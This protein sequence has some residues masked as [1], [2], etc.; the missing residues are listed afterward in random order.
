MNHILTR[1]YTAHYRYSGPDR[2]DITVKGQDPQWK[3]FAPTWDMVMSHKRGSIND[4]EY[5]RRYLLILDKVSCASWDRLLRLPEVTF[6]CFCLEAAF[7]HRNILVNYIL[8]AMGD[9]ITYGGWR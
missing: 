5:I 8:K 7:C 2:V 6:V 3:E 1:V 9:R 4:E